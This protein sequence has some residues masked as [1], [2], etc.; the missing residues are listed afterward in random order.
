MQRPWGRKPAWFVGGAGEPSRGLG[1]QSCGVPDGGRSGQGPA[2][3]GEALGWCSACAGHPAN[4]TSGREVERGFG[5][6]EGKVLGDSRRTLG[7]RPWP[8][9]DLSGRPPQA[10]PDGAPSQL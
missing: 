3:Q 5:P 4:G 6:Q 8:Q 9:R 10:Q 1:V 2:G 7:L